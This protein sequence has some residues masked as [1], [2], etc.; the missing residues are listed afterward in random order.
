VIVEFDLVYANIRGKLPLADNRL[1]LTIV[2]TCA[3]FP[4]GKGMLGG[5]GAAFRADF[6]AAAAGPLA[7]RAVRWTCSEAVIMEAMPAAHD[8]DLWCL[9]Q[10]L[11][12]HGAETQVR[13]SKIIFLR[14]PCGRPV[15]GTVVGGAQIRTPLD[16]ATC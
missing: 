5:R 6:T 1:S 10:A 4:A 3:A 12:Q 13:G 15:T 8:A 2:V 16:H 11:I 14:L 7:P 9:R